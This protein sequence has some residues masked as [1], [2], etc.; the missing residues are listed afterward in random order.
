MLAPMQTCSV[1]RLPYTLFAPHFHSTVSR[2]FARFSTVVFRGSPSTHSILHLRSPCLSPPP[3][4]CEGTAVEQHYSAGPLFDARIS[5]RCA[6]KSLRMVLRWLMSALAA[7]SNRREDEAYKSTLSLST[8][9][10]GEPSPSLPLSS[11][12]WLDLLWLDLL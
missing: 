8:K 12:L 5:L 7:D 3:P 4:E 6:E 2:L 10:G 1:A 9:V 11:L